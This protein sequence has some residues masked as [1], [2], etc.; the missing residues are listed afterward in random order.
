M[1]GK[2]YYEI[3]GVSRDASEQEIKKAYRRLARKYHPDV[4]PGDRKTEEKFKE[5]NEAYEV[6]SDPE[7]RRR[8]DMFGDARPG[9]GSF[10]DFGGFG[11]L[12]DFES[13]F[14]DLFG[15]FFGDWRSSRRTS[16]ERGSDLSL[17]L[18]LSFQEA[19]FGTRKEVEIARLA[20]CPD[21]G[22]SGAEPGTAPESCPE[23]GGTGQIRTARQTFLGRFV[24]TTTCHRCRG[25]GRII[26][27]PCSSCQGQGRRPISERIS[28]DVPAGVS[29]GVQLKL[30]GKGESGLRG[31]PPGDLYVVLRV[32]PHRIFERRGNDLYCRFP[33]TFPQAALGARVQVPTLDGGFVE[34]AIPAGSQTGTVFRIKDKGVP[35]LYGSRRGDLLIEVVVEVPKRLTARQ[36]KLLEEL[37]AEFGEPTATPEEVNEGGEKKRGFFGRIMGE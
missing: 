8:Y 11:G 27:K 7:K 4:N 1:G 23:C 6:L 19:V 2:D 22:G 37:A 33:I 30:A 34:L 16:A 15:M 3:I 29:D 36:K 14:E 17:E 9:S 5:I 25:T 13:P 31:G 21:C 32:V 12:G 26:A 28:I 20:T 10:G 35:Y 24:T 18:S